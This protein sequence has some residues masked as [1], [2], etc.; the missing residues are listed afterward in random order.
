MFWE[1]RQQRTT[2]SKR[3]GVPDKWGYCLQR[4]NLALTVA[5]WKLSLHADKR[6]R[7]RE[8][9]TVKVLKFCAEFR[10]HKWPIKPVERST[11]TNL[12]QLLIAAQHTHLLTCTTHTEK[13]SQPLILCFSLSRSYNFSTARLFLL[14]LV[15][16]TCEPRSCA[17]WTPAG[18]KK[19]C[20]K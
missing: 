14:C 13:N 20:C 4:V 17:G 9:D 5:G 10:L 11:D 19:V 6:R 18:C 8:Y 12:S 1:K 3:R 15:I 2:A 7:D 16:F